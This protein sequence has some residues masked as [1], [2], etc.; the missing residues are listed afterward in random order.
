MWLSTTGVKYVTRVYAYIGKGA[1]SGT[2]EALDTQTQY[3]KPLWNRVNSDEGSQSGVRGYP[4]RLDAS[5]LF[6]LQQ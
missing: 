1:L 6:K 4:P 5:Y 3:C 2:N